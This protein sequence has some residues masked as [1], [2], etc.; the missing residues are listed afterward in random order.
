MLDD[1]Y[2]LSIL[3][4]KLFLFTS[5]SFNLFVLV[6]V[7]LLKALVHLLLFLLL[8]YNKK[9]LGKISEKT[10]P[11]DSLTILQIKKL[12]RIYSTSIKSTSL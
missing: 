4:G 5:L 10:L 9:F 8:V 2:I 1:K 11:S 7:A 6:K 12:Y 3:L